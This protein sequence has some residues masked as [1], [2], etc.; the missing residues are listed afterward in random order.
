[1]FILHFTNN[2]KLLH[3]ISLAWGIRPFYLNKYNDL[4]KA[5]QE[6]TKI[7]KDKKL[8]KDGACVIHV[9]STPLRLRGSTNMMKVSYIWNSFLHK[10]GT[11]IYIW[12]EEYW[13]NNER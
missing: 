3:K 1:M 7:L 10:N 9:G 13:R 11:V 8:L 6:S 2:K 12:I 5:I 4:D